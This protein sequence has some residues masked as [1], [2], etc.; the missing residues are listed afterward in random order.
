MNWLFTYQKKENKNI[1]WFCQ[2]KDNQARTNGHH[3]SS[4][5]TVNRRGSRGSH[6]TNNGWRKALCLEE[7]GSCGEGDCFSGHTGIVGPLLMSI[8]NGYMY[9]CLGIV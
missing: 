4:F 1:P 8:L 5:Y 7:Y 2:T 9:L 6:E 3:Y